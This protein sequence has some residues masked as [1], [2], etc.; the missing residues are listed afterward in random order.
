[1]GK[2]ISLSVFRDEGPL[3]SLC[4]MF[5]GTQSFMGLRIDATYTAFEGNNCNLDIAKENL[6]KC[7]VGLFDRREETAQIFNYWFPW[8]KYDEGVRMN[9][10]SKSANRRKKLKSEFL[11]L[12]LKY[13]QNDKELYEYANLRFEQQLKVINNNEKNLIASSDSFYYKI[14]GLSFPTIE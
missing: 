9:P 2:S 6:G 12:I 1:M 4:K 7:I 5:S 14:K 8:L 3:D 13:N 11:E 10:G